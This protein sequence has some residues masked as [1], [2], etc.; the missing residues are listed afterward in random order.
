MTDNHAA[1]NYL[2]KKIYPE[3]SSIEIPINEYEEKVE[4]LLKKQD[5]LTEM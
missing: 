3:A 1:N 5:K 4:K 2:V